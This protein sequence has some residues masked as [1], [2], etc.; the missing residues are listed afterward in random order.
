EVGEKTRLLHL[1]LAKRKVLLQREIELRRRELDT[2]TDRRQR[3]QRPPVVAIIDDQSESTLSEETHPQNALTQQ[4]EATASEQVIEELSATVAI[5]EAV[6]RRVEAAVVELEAASA[7]LQEEQDDL[8]R[9]LRDAAQRSSQSE[10]CERKPDHREIRRERRRLEQVQHKIE[11]AKARFLA[12]YRLQS[13]EH[14]Q[15]AASIQSQRIL[16]ETEKQAVQESLTRRSAALRKQQRELAR[17][18]QSMIAQ[19]AELDRLK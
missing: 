18:E 4:V 9:V 17:R 19:R 16:L 2:L 8:Q 3:T 15:A 14:V 7:R 10:D 5:A 1:Q 12:A 6:Y 11:A 13:L